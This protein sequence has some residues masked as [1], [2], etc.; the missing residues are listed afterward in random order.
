M[1]P[2]SVAMRFCMSATSLSLLARARDPA[3][4]D[5]WR[6]LVEVYSPLLRQ[7]LQQ[8]EVQTADAEDLLQEVLQVVFRELS[9]FQQGE[10]PGAFRNWLRKVLANRLRNYWRQRDYRPV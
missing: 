1:P 5:A 2:P 6:R 3:D 4:D 9:G 10:R 7:W 8:Y